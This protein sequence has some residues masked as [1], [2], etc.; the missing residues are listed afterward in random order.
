MRTVVAQRRVAGT[1][2]KNINM[3][4][5]SVQELVRPFSSIFGSAVSV[6]QMAMTFHCPAP[7]KPRGHPQYRPP[8][9]AHLD[10]LVS[11]WQT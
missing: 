9:P 10:A 7:A 3:R 11:H 4:L 8:A 2:Q 6:P 1:R 5:S